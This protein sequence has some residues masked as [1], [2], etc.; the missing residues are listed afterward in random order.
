MLQVQWQEGFLSGLLGQLKSRVPQDQ[1]WNKTEKE[2]IK[3][4]LS[5]KWQTDDNSHY[6]PLF[7]KTK[8]P[9]LDL[10]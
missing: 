5:K 6:Q 1:N 9:F 8:F 2:I 10:N 4:D 3:I 7:L